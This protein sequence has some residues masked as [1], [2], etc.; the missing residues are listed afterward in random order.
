MAETSDQARWSLR[1]R[2]TRMLVL[3]A[4]LPS[5]L[6]G[7][8]LLWSQWHDEHD[9]MVLRLDANARVTA[10]AI[11]DF[12]EGERA[13]VA[14][15][16]EHGGEEDAVAQLSLLLRVYPAMLRAFRLD[17]D[18]QVVA[19]LDARGRPVPPASVR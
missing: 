18:G 7:G 4:L 3:A 6:F 12:L 8:A 14:L 10:N 11:D 16:A 17:A 5:L 13:G 1:Q 15:L 2:L 9:A 19:A